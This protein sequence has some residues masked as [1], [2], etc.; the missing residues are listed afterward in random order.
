MYELRTE[1]EIKASAEQVWD[2]LSDFGAYGQWNPFVRE[3]AGGE[4]TAVGTKLG[5]T[6]SPPGGKAMR[7]SPSVTEWEPGQRFAW[8]GH[9]L[10]PG[11]FDGEHR[12]ELEPTTD[13]VRLVH[14]ERFRGVLVPFMKKMIDGSTRAGFEAMNEALKQRAENAVRS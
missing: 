8:L 14:S 4:P 13:G 6:I 10:V 12:Y 11:L 3:L 5:V 7:F 1:I 2:I 9:L